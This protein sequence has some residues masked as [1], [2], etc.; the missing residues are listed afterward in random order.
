MDKPKT[1]FFWAAGCGGCEEAVIDLGVGLLDVV[2]ALE[3]VFWPAALDF[4]RSDLES[5]ADGSIAASFIN[6]SVRTGEQEEMV[7]LLRRKSASVVALGTCACMGGIPGLANFWNGKSLMDRAYREVPSL[8]NPGGP[9]PETRTVFPGGK[10]E[11]PEFYDSVFTLEQIIPVDYYLPGCAPPPELLSGALKSF[12]EGTLPPKGSVLAPDKQLCDTCPRR[13]SKPERILVKKFNRMHEMQTDGEKCFLV[14]GV[15]C[16]GSA[17]RSG[18]GER[19]IRVNMPCRGCFG[20]TSPVFDQGAK[21]LSAL[22]S[23]MDARDDE[24]AVRI[25]DTITDPAGIFYMYGFPASL[26]HRR[27]KEWACNEK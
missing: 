11:L 15:I 12:L 27:W 1:A 2:E 14:D 3:L 13:D 17:T 26:L 10:L 20:P 23:L 5:M 21:I 8:I 16:M 24:E 7:K 18:C 4:K 25:A 22:S 6:G 9:L 19:C